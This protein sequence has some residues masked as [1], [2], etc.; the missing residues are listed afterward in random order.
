MFKGLTVS[1]NTLAI[2]RGKDALVDFSGD[3][4]T[5]GSVEGSFAMPGMAWP[6]AEGKFKQVGMELAPTPAL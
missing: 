2:L 3:F 4:V 6:P 1:A 5:G